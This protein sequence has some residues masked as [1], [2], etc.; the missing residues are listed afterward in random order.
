MK[1]H[2]VFL[3]GRYDWQISRSSY[4][5]PTLPIG[6]CIFQEEHDGHKLVSAFGEQGN[7][8]L[9]SLGRQQHGDNDC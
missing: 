5:S 7:N 9:Q 2:F 3:Q 6:H 1:F 8:G 4:T